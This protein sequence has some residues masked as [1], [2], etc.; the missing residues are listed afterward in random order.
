MTGEEDRPPTNHLASRP[1]ASSKLTR[2]SYHSP[3]PSPFN[4]RS[5]FSI[6]KISSMP[7]LSK[8][9]ERNICP[10][11]LHALLYS[12]S[13]IIQN[14]LKTL[15]DYGFLFQLLVRVLLWLPI[16]RNS[17]GR[18]WGNCRRCTESEDWLIRTVHCPGKCMKDHKNKYQLILEY[19][20]AQQISRVTFHRQK[21]TR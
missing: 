16:L 14:I 21:L 13:K 7:G 1:R 11:V 4:R 20:C 17:S 10:Q 2:S 18:W 9:T 3:R 15:E 8:N 6:P 19:C 12:L 5:L